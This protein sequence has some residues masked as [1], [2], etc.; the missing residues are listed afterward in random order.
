MQSKNNK[1]INKDINQDI[2]Q[3]K[4]FKKV[5]DDKTATLKKLEIELIGEIPQEV[6]DQLKKINKGDSGLI[7]IKGPSIGEKFLIK[8][9]TLTIGRS[10]DSDILLDDITV[11]RHHAVIKKINDH[12]ELEDLNSL[13]GT[14]LNGEI[15]NNSVNLKYGDKIQIGKYIFIFFTYI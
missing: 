13:N 1:D 4:K 2:N 9:N 6:Q 12:F 8:E 11:S 7:V 3:D 10:A 5:E 14:Y 15:I